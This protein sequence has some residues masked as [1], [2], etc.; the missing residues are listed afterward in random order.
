MRG[1]APTLL[2]FLNEKGEL[3]VARVRTGLTD[4]QHTVVE[5]PRIKEGMQVIVAVNTPTQAPNAAANPFGGQGGFGGP[6]G[7]FQGG[8][9]Q[10]G[11]NRR[12]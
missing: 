10:G 6:P 3:D 11:G 8:G 12:F 2:W 4:G 5:S 7:G 1:Q 9:F